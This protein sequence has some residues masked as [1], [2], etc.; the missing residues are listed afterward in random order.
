MRP[1]GVPEDADAATQLAR[2]PRP[3]KATTITD[4]GIHAADSSDPGI[5]TTLSGDGVVE[6][7]SL[8]GTSIDRY[9]ITA[10]LGAGGMGV[11]YA[12]KDPAL[13]RRVAL[14]VLPAR[15]HER[16]TPLE[17]R[18][19]REAQALAKLDHPN[20]VAVYDVGVA[21]RSVFVAMQ[22]VDGQTLAE[23]LE[24]ER[25]GPR[26]I[27]ELFLAAGR[28]LAAAHAAGIVHR[29][30]KPSNLL[31]DRNGRVKVGDFGLA[32]GADEVEESLTTTERSLLHE[33]MTRAGAVMGTPIYMSP[34]QHRGEPATARSDQF[35][36]CVCLWE[37]LFDGHPF[38]AG[39]WNAGTALVT[40]SKDAVR[41]PDRRGVPARVVR[42]L[43]RGLRHDP[44]ARWPSIESLLDQ[45]APRSRA[46][47]GWTAVGVAAIAGA[48][49]VTASIRG[50]A[51]RDSCRAA[52]TKIDKVWPA[53]A[54]ELRAAI[55]AAPIPDA[56]GTAA[57]VVTG[58]D[59]YAAQWK[60]LRL[61]ACDASDRGDATA[62]LRDLQL[63]CLDD[64]L[65]VLDAMVG[66]LARGDA[67]VIARG[68]DA[69]DG[70][71][72]L[73]DC[74][75]SS[76][77]ATNP[78]PAGALVAISE[79]RGDLAKA[80]RLDR[81]D[82]HVEA[83]ASLDAIVA[84][85]EELGYAPLIA[86]A[87]TVQADILGTDLQ[88]SG[89]IAARAAEIAMAAHADRTAATALSLAIYAAAS[90]GDR[91]RAAT[92]VPLARAAAARTGD[93]H[94]AVAAEISGGIAAIADA[95]YDEALTICRTALD[96]I[97]EVQTEAGHARQALVCLVQASLFKGDVDGAA[98]FAEKQLALAEARYGAG[99]YGTV[100]ALG[101]LAKVRRRQGRLDEA[102]ALVERELALHRKVGG[103]DT[104]VAESLLT[105]A[106]MKHES[107]KPAEGLP[108]AEEAL[109]IMEREDPESITAINAHTTLA[110]QLR[111]LGRREEMRTHY[112]RALALAEKRLSP[113][114]QML[115]TIRMSFGSALSEDGE[116][117]RALELL[118]LSEEALARAHNPRAIVPA[119]AR[120]EILLERGRYAEALPL[121]ETAVTAL[122]ASKTDAFNLL[123]AKL[124]L[125]DALW[126]TKLDRARAK[127]L[128]REVRDASVKRGEGG[129]E[130]VV[131]CDRWLKAH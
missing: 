128:V 21:E 80:R 7:D 90:H 35:S 52:V 10:R 1:M 56:A 17:A 106:Q 112:E 127:K 108:L 121:L 130:M 82:R 22:L 126:E 19:R 43:R 41:E 98:G 38:V 37:A 31:V 101:R 28:G 102:Y 124:G 103:D 84:R 92:L 69:V 14:K 107:G 129:A 29:D 86:E 62:A 48:V 118:R 119:I 100:D 42:A 120:A 111:L 89:E 54:A 99:T 8:V 85:A 95:R 109:A 20:V 123:I 81:A 88:R 117:D 67:K 87:L 23:L 83:L 49:A 57:R 104:R 26:R 11:V 125:A 12:A 2:S 61:D 131:E 6:E 116:L 33:R 105:L 58:I 73:D 72:R 55:T 97:G 65:H 110:Q 68:V 32:R 115:A 27:L 47:L 45:L 93:P 114:D 16:R 40:M 9:Q 74:G 66:D 91:A 60:Q 5:A 3:V 71:P 25:P 77:A 94:L 4:T 59:R 39:R 50:G 13:D 75:A 30:V 36:F 96:R 122:E 24:V 79:I 53:R 76:L 34:E 64:D 113:D 18:L 70:L 78:P 15:D 46:T 51:P 63:R 44:D